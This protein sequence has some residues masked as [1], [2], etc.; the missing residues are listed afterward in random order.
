MKDKTEEKEHLKAVHE[1]SI[2]SLEPDDFE[3]MVQLLNTLAKHRHIDFNEV[4]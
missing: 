4:F 1:M 3:K 2:E